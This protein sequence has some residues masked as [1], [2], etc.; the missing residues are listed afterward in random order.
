MKLYRKAAIIFVRNPKNGL[1]FFAERIDYPGAWQVPQ[2]GVEEGESHLEGAVR[3]LKEETGIRT[4]KLLRNTQN[5]YKYDFP[6]AAL[7][8]F[9]SKNSDSYFVG[10]EARFFLFDFLGDESEI[11]LAYSKEVEFLHWKWTQL[12]DILD[13][14]VDFKKDAFNAAAEELFPQEL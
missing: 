4:V 6:E 8:K 7:K 3:E 2:G 1:Y 11:N 14:V 12:K 13:S 9:R 10:Q 5:L